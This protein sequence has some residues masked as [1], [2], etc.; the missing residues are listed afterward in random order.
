MIIPRNLLLHTF[1]MAIFLY[2]SSASN[3]Q[4]ICEEDQFLWGNAKTGMKI[5]E[6][7][8]LYPRSVLQANPAVYDDNMKELMILGGFHIAD[9][10][11]TV[12]FLFV[13]ERLCRVL[14]RAVS[15]SINDKEKFY[16]SS[17]SRLSDLL[18]VKYGA[19]F[20]DTQD[21]NIELGIHH[22]EQHWKSD[23]LNVNLEGFH[24]QNTQFVHVSIRYDRQLGEIEKLV[25][26]GELEKL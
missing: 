12:R 15:E 17:L 16:K 6:L 5:E 25:R 11:V 9:I 3:A 23:G 24:D 2:V 18:T 8:R 10:P 22:F 13:N 4:E 26:E 20:V 7:G 14:L 1:V 19:P 21:S